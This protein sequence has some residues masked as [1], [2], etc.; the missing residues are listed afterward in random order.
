MPKA[1]ASLIGSQES[2]VAE[3][4]AKLEQMTGYRGED[5][6]VLAEIEAAAR[7][8]IAILGLD[9]CDTK[10]RELYYALIGRYH[11]DNNHLEDILG[12]EI[13][14]SATK[15]L[16][17]AVE[18][19]S[20]ARVPRDIWVVKHTV[21][22]EL[23]RQHPPRKLMKLL[24]YRSIESMLKR[25]NIAQIYALL[26]LVESSRWLSVF[27]KMHTKFEA[28]QFETIKAEVII[29]PT[30]I[31]N[32]LGVKDK[33][34]ST[35][36]QLGVTVLWPTSAAAR[37][38]TL[39]LSARLLQVTSNLR[40]TN[41]YLKLQQFQPNFGE[42]LAKTW[43]TSDAPGVF[44]NNLPIPWRSLHAHYGKCPAS[45]HPTALE[46]HIQAEDLFYQSAAQ[47]IA[48][49][50]SLGQWWAQ[51]EKLATLYKSGPVSM[52]LIDVS[53]NYAYGLSYRKR[54]FT[55]FQAECMDELMHRYLA[56]QAVE[57]HLLGQLEKTAS[58]G[59]SNELFKVGS[60]TI[61]RR[62]ANS[63]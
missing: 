43:M 49:I 1:I 14:D 39:G 3:A 55:A 30:K 7:K 40:G 41:T 35:A 18:F 21:A 16:K 61:N 25:D 53:A 28:N 32:K 22:K 5:I 6:H 48:S 31:A 27:W 36:P 45:Q 63:A 9:P 38:G 58:K 44:L 52:N 17:I 57:E 59:K 12:V 46:P 62:R 23:L 47:A 33:V 34:I 19:S 56:Y 20:H 60:I 50:F 10:G 29:I 4:I 8:H 37:V 13:G 24:N 2:V 11:V 26:S 42:I 54:K 15:R 51:S